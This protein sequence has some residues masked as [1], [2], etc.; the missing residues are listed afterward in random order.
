MLP[1]LKVPYTEKEAAKAA[2][3]RWDA[4]ARRWYAPHGL[5]PDLMRWRAPDTPDPDVEDL[6]EDPLCAPLPRLDD[7]G[8]CSNC[9]T[10]QRRAD[11]PVT[12]FKLDPYRGEDPPGEW[13]HACPK[14]GQAWRQ[15]GGVNALYYWHAIEPGPDLPWGW[16]LVATCLHQH[17]ARQD[18][19][20]HHS[21]SC[22]RAYE[23]LGVP[24][25]LHGNHRSGGETDF[26]TAFVVYQNAD[27]SMKA[28]ALDSKR[29]A[30]PREPA[31]LLLDAATN[32]SGIARLEG[33]DNVGEYTRRTWAND[34]WLEH[35]YL[36]CAQ[37]IPAIRQRNHE[38]NSQT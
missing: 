36:A 1:Y 17:A 30:T 5:T 7:I 14:C 38:F 21:C 26:R 9:G 29:P 6:T 27:G 20:A 18:T 34:S 31:P 4:D 35:G 32:E 15:I 3:A 22:P 33:G 28:A 23:Y 37:A 13:R 11:A 24:V 19:L 10:Y 12:Y 2:G 25:V 8:W 16:W